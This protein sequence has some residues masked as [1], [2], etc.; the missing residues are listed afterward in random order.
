MCNH[1]K[2]EE[3]KVYAPKDSV[4]IVR[5]DPKHAPSI[6]VLKER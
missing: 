2:F 3:Q 1:G 5:Y 4:V 6:R